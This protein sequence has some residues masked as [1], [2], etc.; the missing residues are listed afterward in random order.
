M[1][2]SPADIIDL[3][4][5]YNQ[6]GTPVPDDVQTAYR[7]LPDEALRTIAQKALDDATSLV[8]PFAG[9]ELDIDLER[10]YSEMD[11]LWHLHKVLLE[12]SSITELVEDLSYELGLLEA[13]LV[14]RH[15]SEPTVISRRRRQGW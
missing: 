12:D 6:T 5:V 14:T 8:V 9:P 10:L 3:V 1:D 7:N 13:T 4:S 2:L 15:G 11:R